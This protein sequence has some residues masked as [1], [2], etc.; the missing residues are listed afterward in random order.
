MSALLDVKV[1]YAGRW[2]GV[3][4]SLGMAQEYFNGKHGDCPSC[5]DTRKNARWHP[6]KQY[7]ICSKCGITGPMDLAMILTGESFQQTA[8]R[9]RGEKISMEQT[10]KVQDLEKDTARLKAIYAARKPLDSSYLKL[11]G[12]SVVPQQNVFSVDAA[13]YWTEQ[14][15]KW[16]KEVLPAMVAAIRNVA[17]ETVSYHMTYLKDGN[18]HGR[19]VLPPIKLLQG[20]AIQLFKPVDGVLAIAEGIETALA[21]HQLEGLPVWATGNAWQMEVLEIPSDIKELHIYADSDPS[22]TGQQ[23]AYTLAKRMATKGVKVRVH[24]LLGEFWKTDEGDGGDFLDF[25]N[26]S[27]HQ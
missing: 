17:G 14:D 8:N 7:N 19:K 2:D 12:L 1:Q 4:K 11:R 21:V 20:A 22:F 9:I 16:R 15:G 26:R 10:A 6:V 13:D 23:A 27:C 24:L 25:L 3:L 5:G 18:K